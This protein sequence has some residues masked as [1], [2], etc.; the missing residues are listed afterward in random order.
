MHNQFPI[1]G[2]GASAGGLEPLEQFFDRIS[3]HLGYAFVVIQHLAPHHK[4]LMDEL[5]ARH[6][7][8]PIVIIQNEMPI[9]PNQIYLNPPQ[10]FVEI[11]NGKFVLSDKEDR[12]LS[13]PI[14]T[15]FASLA[16][17][18][19][20]LSCAIVL[21]G[22]GSDGTE[23]VKYIKDHG[24]LVI[25][26]DPETA[27]FDGMPKNAIHSG[28]V[29]VVCEVSQMGKEL[30]KF[31]QTRVEL[32][33]VLE[34]EPEQQNF[35]RNILKQVK[36]QIGVDFSGYK[37]ST[38]HR[39]TLRRMSI[40]GCKN[41]IDY[42]KYLER[43][44]GEG[45]MLA[46]ELLIG[47]TRFFRDEGAFET[48][49]MKVI[50][51]IIE[52]NKANKVI[53]VWVP[54]CST[55]EEAY[56]IAI[57]F[58]EYLR[59]KKLNYDITIFATDLDKEAIKNAANRIFPESIGAEIPSELLTT[60]F[61]PQKG[62]YQVVKSIR[63]MIVFSAQNVIQ[64]PPFSKIDLI[65][66]RNFLIYLN[67]EF[68]RKVFGVFQFSLKLNGYLFLGMSE[69]VGDLGDHF[70]EIDKKHKIYQSKSNKKISPT[71][72]GIRK[73]EL[74]SANELRDK[75]SSEAEIF[76][77]FHQGKR[78]TG[79]IQDLLIQSF[80][81]DNLIFSENFELI[82]TTGKVNS[83]LKLPI[84]EI[85]TNILKMLPDAISMAFEL[86]ASRVL[87][88]GKVANI[89][90]FTPEGVMAE[91]YGNK[92]INIQIHLLNTKFN[93]K[94]L[95]ATFVPVYMDS[96]QPEEDVLSMD[97]DL[98]SKEKIDIL[99]RELRINRENLQTTIEELES[100]NE[101]L[102]AANEELQSSNEELESVNEELYTVNAE[103]QEKLLELSE[104]N[105]D[106]NNLI[107]STDI[108]ILFLD[109]NL[110]IRRFTPAI[111]PILQLMPHDIGRH[112]SH[113]RS[114]F[115]IADFMVHLEQVMDTLTSS[116][117]S[118]ND[119][120]EKNYILKITPFKS[121]KKE[122]QGVVLAF[123][124]ISDV[125]NSQVE[126]KLSN[127][128][129]K[130][131]TKKFN[132]QS[133]LFELIANNSRDMITILNLDAEIEYSSPST[134]EIT[135]YRPS[136]FNIINPIKTIPNTKHK[137]LWKEAFKA[138]PQ[139]KNPGLIQY[140]IKTKIGLERWVETS[141][142][143]IKNEAGFVVKVL[144][145]TRDINQR[146][147]KDEE[148]RKLS[149][150]AHQT[151]NAIII[152]DKNGLI[153]FVNDSF[154]KISGYSE[155]EVLGLKPGSFLQGPE[156]DQKV[157]QTMSDSLK[158][159]SPFNVELIN[160]TKS[161]NKYWVKIQAEPLYDQDQ[162]CIGFFS[163]QSDIS[164]QKEYEAQISKLNA[165][166]SEHN[167]KLEE[168][169][170]ALDEFAYVVSH[171]LK[172]P[173]RNIKSM[174][175]LL[176]KKQE[177]IDE[178]KRTQ[179]FNIIV[180]ASNE[181]SRLIDNLLEY[182]RS[183]RLEEPLQ[184]VHV[185]T[186]IHE[187]IRIHREELDL[188]GGEIEVDLRVKEKIYLYP[189]LF[190]RLLSNLISN[191]IKY[192]GNNIPKI[193]I[194]LKE[195]ES[196]YLF[197]VSDNGIGIAPENHENIFKIFNT[198]QQRDDNNGIGLSVCKK[199]VEIHGG[200]IWVESKINNGAKFFFEIDKFELK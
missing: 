183:G 105:D 71:I 170:K 107:Q 84:G 2:L 142:K 87:E 143:P 16:E 137:N 37:F 134:L 169:N 41:L 131:I 65:T 146:V 148:L 103:F 38:I 112:I 190:K 85:S 34:N 122:I 99:E 14:S 150:V 82:Y 29:D 116:E 153:T 68:Q 119:I 126:L 17:Q 124:D 67:S 95:A 133:E 128:E 27:K 125:I 39:R 173:L 101:E 192:R 97:L 11:E 63:E 52:A 90:N 43:T 19:H 40:I 69:T 118:L 51:Q 94:L 179:Y 136:E 196:E 195:K 31:F 177:D 86:I 193:T 111:K 139:G 48:L 159:N 189:I 25:A 12:K 108:A 36:I 140:K 57:L 127:D 100:S 184:K 45:Q 191:S 33:K 162:N 81:P 64:D 199:I 13:F 55:G 152:T 35:I 77:P 70:E 75:S 147:L 66:C 106:L 8:M 123:I 72:K 62:G 109:S 92:N 23:G 164:R 181:L 26:Q 21:S 102:Q 32:L 30:I 187:V 158:K 144:G 135:G 157:I 80:L 175:K 149:L 163:V 7:K 186:L 59:V 160:Y 42:E 24:G 110:H 178:E 156:S 60:Y 141:L 56:S 4:S 93:E 129:L 161:G 78:I 172:A 117:I 74:M 76:N 198:I 46:K 89:N 115:Q 166:L 83:W 138:I 121:R 155:K 120:N 98:A 96:K 58:K 104:T 5:L 22:T 197:I 113:F 91:S 54:A 28:V 114:K 10:K 9:L 168:M 79:E 200:R 145:T 88:T 73:L 194:E 20:H 15:F 151:S 18:M 176:Q 50:P 132:Q 154:E 47:V 182:S 185:D 171:D 174:I 130:N 167:K 3:P 165:Y 1:V 188:L 53:R 6:T 61:L 180:N 44:P 49:K